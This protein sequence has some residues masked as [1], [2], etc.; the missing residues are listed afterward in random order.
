MFGQDLLDRRPKQP[1]HQTTLVEVS[2]NSRPSWGA[3]SPK[4]LH[5]HP[6]QVPP[7]TQVG[8]G[9]PTN[10]RTLERT[11]GAAWNRP[12][13]SSGERRVTTGA[14]GGKTNK[15]KTDEEEERGG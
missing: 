1:T 4:P 13:V 7:A 14:T 8:G 11:P 10:I 5:L 12:P 9:T 15:R 3:P 2:R 6:S